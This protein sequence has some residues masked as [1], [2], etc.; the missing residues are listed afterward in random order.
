VGSDICNYTNVFCASL[1]SSAVSRGRRHRGD[2]AVT[3]IDLNHSDITG[4]PPPRRSSASLPTS[5]CST[6]TPQA[7]QQHPPRFV[8][9]CTT[10]HQCH[11]SPFSCTPARR[12]QPI[13]RQVFHHIITSCIHRHN[14]T[15]VPLSRMFAFVLVLLRARLS[16]AARDCQWRS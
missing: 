6:S 9:H 13:V 3:G 16:V 8:E 10:A 15:W 14:A 4:S 2:L 5:R 1:P 11:R 12:Y 7:H